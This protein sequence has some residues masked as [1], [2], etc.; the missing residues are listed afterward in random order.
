MSIEKEISNS[1]ATLASAMLTK[2]ANM[3]SRIQNIEKA[4]DFSSTI[5]NLGEKLVRSKELQSFIKGKNPIAT[6]PI[7]QL[8]IKTAI[9]GDHTQNHPLNIATRPPIAP[10]ATRKLFIRDLLL[11]G[12]TTQSAV[13]YPVENVFTNNAGVQV[14]GSPEAFENVALAESGVTFTLGFQPV[15]T[16][17]HFIHVSKQVLDDSDVLNAFL[18]TR[19]L[20]GARIKEESQILNGTNANGQLN[21]LITAATAYTAQSP[22]LSNEIDIIRDAIKQ[23]EVADYSPSAIILNPVDWQTIDNRK[24]SSGGDDYAIGDP[25]IMGVPILWRLPVI[26]TNSI[27]AGTFLVGDFARAAALFD[28]EDA[29][30]QVSHHDDTN[31][32]KGMVTLKV[33]E[34]VS[35]VVTNSG[36]LITGSL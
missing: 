29:L 12:R 7:S 22:Q 31:F 32:Q 14:A 1:L 9:I 26:S 24:S 33:D 20:Y 25:G 13:E 27:A 36:A 28:R 4:F 23:L 6:I 16:I 15:V 18:R 3:D 21:G 35:Q 30:F 10:G 34:R 8:E 5:E 11:A 19:L 17:G 2:S